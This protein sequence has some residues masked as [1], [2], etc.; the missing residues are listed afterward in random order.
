MEVNQWARFDGWNHDPRCKGPHIEWRASSGGYSIDKEFAGNLEGQ[1]PIV[2]Y[3]GGEGDRL[4][5]Q[6]V[7]KLGTIVG[8]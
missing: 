4:A 8:G 3:A 5:V 1:R 7:E 2:C 6:F